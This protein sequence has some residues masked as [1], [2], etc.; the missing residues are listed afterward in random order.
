MMQVASKL[1]GLLALLLGVGA[2]NAFDIGLSVP[3]LE[4]RAKVR[5][6]AVEPPSLQSAAARPSYQLASGML[7]GDYYFNLDRWGLAAGLR[8]SGGMLFKGATTLSEFAMPLDVQADLPLS[9]PAANLSNTGPV[10]ESLGTLP[11]FGLGYTRLGLWG[12]WGITADVGVVAWQG[13]TALLSGR[14]LSNTRN[15]D[16]AVRDIRFR[17]L[18]QMG[19]RYAF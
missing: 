16:D 2:A 8:A 9:R 11:Y 5:L 4:W 1:S 12:G 6:G 15:L 17:P 7:M 19:V 10:N 13:S 3:T 14:T 18:V